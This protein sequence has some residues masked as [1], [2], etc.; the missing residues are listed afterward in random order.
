[1]IAEFPPMIASM[2]SM[3]TM[4]LTVHSTMSGIFGQMDDL[5]NNATAM[6]QGLRHRE[7]RRLV[8][9]AAGKFSTTQISNEP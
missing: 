8:L 1:M 6:G 2:E 4:M 7:K 3:R 5:S 9:L